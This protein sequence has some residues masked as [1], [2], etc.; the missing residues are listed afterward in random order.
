MAAPIK[1]HY[2][3]EETDLHVAQAVTEASAISQIRNLASTDLVVTFS[4]VA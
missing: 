1:L 2:N 4:N 3:T